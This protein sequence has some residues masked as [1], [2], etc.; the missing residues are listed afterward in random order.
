MFSAQ[1]QLKA[2]S[3]EPV[4]AVVA[5]FATDPLHP[6]LRFVFDA[7]GMPHRIIFAG[8]NQV[9]RELIDPFGSF[10]SHRDGIHVVLLRFSDI[11]PANVPLHASYDQIAAPILA[12]LIE[13][14]RIH[15]SRAPSVPLIF[16]FCPERQENLSHTRHSAVLREAEISLAR[17]LNAEGVKTITSHELL[18][19]Y[20]VNR[21]D[22]PIADKLAHIPYTEQGF[23]VIALTITRKVRS[24]VAPMFKVLV[25]DADNTIWTGVVAEDGPAGIVIDE[26]RLEIQRYALTQRAAGVLLCLCSRNSMSDIQEAFKQRSMPLRLNH[27]SA[28]RVNFDKKSSNV[29]DI[30]RE[31][32]LGLDSIVFVDDDP[33]ECAEVS[34]RCRDVLTINL[35][36]NASAAATMLRNL[37]AFDKWQTTK[38]D[39]ERASYYSDEK[40]RNTLRSGSISVSSFLASLRIRIH[41][42]EPSDNE[43]SRLAQL[44]FRTNQFNFTQLRLTENELRDSSFESLKVEVSD[45]FGDYGIVGLI[46]FRQEDETL[47]V[48]T[49]LLSCRALQRG[50][51][52][53]MMAHLGAT[54]SSRGLSFVESR[55]KYT[56]KNIPAEQFLRAVGN[57]W[58]NSYDGGMSVKLPAD[59]AQ[60]VAYDPERLVPSPP[61]SATTVGR[62][63]VRVPDA[64]RYISAE[65]TQVTAQVSEISAPTST[66]QRDILQFIAT[67]LQTPEAV[68][69]G[70]SRR[71]LKT[72]PKQHFNFAS[73]AAAELYLNKMVEEMLGVPIGRADDLFANLSIDSL[74]LVRIT[75]IVGSRFGWIPEIGTFQEVRTIAGL[76]QRIWENVGSGERSTDSTLATRE[77]IPGCIHVIRRSGEKRPLFL[78]RPSS[79][80]G[81]GLA[82]LSLA[83]KIEHTRPIYVFQNRPLLE[84]GLP[85]KSIREMSH[86]YLSAMRKLQPHG[87]YILGGW[88][89][90]GKIAFEMANLL[91]A[92][93]EQISKLLLF[94]T[95][96]PSDR[97]DR[98][99]YLRHRTCIKDELGALTQGDHRCNAH[100][101][102]TLLQR[103]V[104]PIRRFELLAYYA[105]ENNNPA[106]VDG[107]FPGLFDIKKLELMPTVAMWQ[108]IYD[109]LLEAEGMAGSDFQEPAAD[110]RTGYRFLACD[111]EMDV[112]Y[113]T[114]WEYPQKATML[115]IRGGHVVLSRWKPFL[116]LEPEV[117]A[118]DMKSRYQ[119]VSPHNSMMQDENVSLM[120][121]DL[122]RLLEEGDC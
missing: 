37:W 52:Y 50:V 1:D 114:K 24:S 35:P 55:L 102:P 16:V 6:I 85:Y 58:I 96:A 97:H 59:E 68:L 12:E 118:F 89:L 119:G 54:A 110:I 34:I 69:K 77:D 42:T 67:E 17:Q 39:R 95:S 48:E 81:G 43:L 14:V 75:A 11:I 36:Q 47:I 62:T 94:D 83:K 104:S 113:E 5:S 33:I 65:Q 93:G 46:S 115:V 13:H 106:C 111:H 45:R 84:R 116:K 15:N 99:K 7:T 112:M 107:I 108:F 56:E 101:L 23:A 20:A 63:R 25:L 92:E 32:C 41:I 90:G 74:M 53:A 64:T 3:P 121:D 72:S 60:R 66:M 51:E 88:C 103:E 19:F 29:I 8:Y 57:R 28:F 44:T 76:A 10:A 120:S 109:S 70:V 49:F 79:N 122:N 87:P 4:L 31:L 9:L 30:A 22:D 78:V 98:I 18:S 61:L 105:Y 91:A 40:S 82:Y 2:S 100:A 27:F 73:L 86:E 38:E 80:A 26:E 117:F 71:N 21:W